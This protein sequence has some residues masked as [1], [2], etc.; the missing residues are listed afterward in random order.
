MNGYYYAVTGVEVKKGYDC[1]FNNDGSSEKLFSDL[2]KAE[3]RFYDLLANL[4]AIV[5]NGDADHY[6]FEVSCDGFPKAKVVIGGD[7][8]YIKTIYLAIE[9]FEI[10]E[11]S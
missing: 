3:E 8:N 7:Y 9:C 6:S 10:E 2:E 11:E 1:G 5:K 4:I